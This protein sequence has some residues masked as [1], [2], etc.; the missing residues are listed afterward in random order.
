[1]EIS[2]HNTISFI[3]QKVCQI[4][5]ANSK[6]TECEVYMMRNIDREERK[7]INDH[8]ENASFYDLEWSEQGSILTLRW[9]PSKI[10]SFVENEK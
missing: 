6:F 8:L 7:I 5:R 1:M 9:D 10:L 3:I 4:S 2:T